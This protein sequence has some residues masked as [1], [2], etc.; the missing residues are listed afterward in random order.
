MNDSLNIDVCDV[1]Q[2]IIPLYHDN[3]CSEKSKQYVETHIKS[4]KKC[5]DLL[6][7][8]N[9][10]DSY[11]KKIKSETQNVL[12]HHA[13]QEKTLAMKIGMII[14]ALLLLPV[15][16]V[17]LVTMSGGADLRTDAVL[18]ASM[19]LAAGLT[20]VPLMSRKNKFS[21]MI[22]V[23]TLALLLVIFTSHQ[24]FYHGSILE[25]FEIAFSVVFGLSIPFFPFVIHQASLPDGLQDKKGLITMLW[26]TT[27]FYLMM[28]SFGIVY[29][30]AM[31]D[32]LC[33]GTFGISLPWAIF[34]I[35][36]YLGNN[37]LF[38]TGGILLAI[39]AWL[40]IGTL[41]KWVTIEVGNHPGVATIII[42]ATLTTLG[43]LFSLVGLIKGNK[44]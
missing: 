13:K 25:F 37:R 34:V 33:I 29:P 14:A 38:K 44:K 3:V 18:I 9:A 17:L 12:A 19:L 42:Y 7:S 30:E 41:F 40:W 27:W 1:I 35:A 39:D 24:L 15:I 5:A 36:R 26:D 8:L 43:A 20:V 16:I 10:E 32:L 11:E 23:S 2:D 21:K 6:K 4:C 31:H 22:I 28:F